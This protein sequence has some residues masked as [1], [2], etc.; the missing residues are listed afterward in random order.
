[1]TLAVLVLASLP[2]VAFAQDANG[3]GPVDW[4]YSIPAA[5]AAVVFKAWHSFKKFANSG[6]GQLV[7]ISQTSQELEAERDRALQE[8]ERLKAAHE[9]L[10]ELEQIKAESAAAAKAHAAETAAGREREE[11]LAAEI[12]DM[13]TRLHE[14][15]RLAK[16]EALIRDEHDDDDPTS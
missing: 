8:V 7:W 12:E 3:E 2:A 14:L 5:F 15:D 4:R 13:Q 16:F 11:A 9:Q 1:M 6:K 10:R